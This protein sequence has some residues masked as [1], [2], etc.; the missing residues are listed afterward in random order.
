M[1]S[2]RRIF[3]PAAV[4]FLLMV[5]LPLPTTLPGRDAAAQK[6]HFPTRGGL[7]RD[8]PDSTRLIRLYNR[9]IALNLS[10]PKAFPSATIDSVM[11][12]VRGAGMTERIGA[13]A[14]FFR[15][16]GETEY[17]FGL[18]SLGYAAQGLLVDDRH[19]DCVLFFYRTTELGRSSTALEAVQ[20]AYGTR[21]YGAPIAEA[22]D[23]KGRV[24]YDHPAHLDYT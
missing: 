18:D 13:W 21:F 23:P 1:R 7:M 16:R 22:V 6:I 8:E 24:D 19:M 11:Y 2:I 10:G 4:G 12:R 9:M 20:F 5:S 17:L 15:E 14:E 3:V